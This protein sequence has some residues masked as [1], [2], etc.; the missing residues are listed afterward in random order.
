[1]TSTL[2]LLTL[3]EF[4]AAD[5]AELRAMLA[6]CS[7]RTI[8]WRF[9]GEG[10]AMTEQF[11]A[12]TVRSCSLVTLVARMDGELIGIGSVEAGLPH[13]LAILVEDRW[14]RQGVGRRLATALAAAAAERGA[15]ELHAVLAIT[16][17]PALRLVLSLWQGARLSAP[18]AG[19]RT[20]VVPVSGTGVMQA[21]SRRAPPEADGRHAE[22]VP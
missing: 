22:S 6:R 5:A 21:A 7:R 13:E 20:C 1:M 15:V 4:T 18:D 8:R 12:A 3:A 11:V 19:E 10:A 16:N 9:L 14:Q 2:A 17:F